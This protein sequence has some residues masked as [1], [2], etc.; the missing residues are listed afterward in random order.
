M[1]ST[2]TLDPAAITRPGVSGHEYDLMLTA[3]TTTA[4]QLGP[5]VESNALAQELATLCQPF[6]ATTTK[7]TDYSKCDS[8]AHW[9]A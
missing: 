3:A 5:V 9:A 1:N 6:Q 4:R 8:G 2:A 7:T